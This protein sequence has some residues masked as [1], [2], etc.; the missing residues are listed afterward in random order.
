[1]LLQTTIGRI[2]LNNE[3]LE[4]MQFR[5]RQVPK[6][7]LQE[8]IADCYKYYTNLD[9]LTEED[10]DT[11]RAMHGDRSRD[12]LARI[13][14][15][16]R[17]AD[18]AD[19]IKALGFK[20]ATR[21]GMTVALRISRCRWP[22]SRSWSNSDAQVDRCREAVPPRPDHRGGALHR[23]SSKIWQDATKQTTEAVKDI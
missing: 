19:K 7:G 6:K 12:E 14:G 10:L 9:N 2:I 13:Y 1:M 17:T 3:L 16:E 5:N 15:S 4:P 23:R 22:R 21:G 8:I 11:I 20:Y 18:Q